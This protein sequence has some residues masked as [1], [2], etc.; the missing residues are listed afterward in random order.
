[1][2]KQIAHNNPN[3]STNKE[4]KAFVIGLSQKTTKPI[5]FDYFSSRF[6]SL[7]KVE[8]LK[9]NKKTGKIKGYGFLILN[10]KIEFERLISLKN[11][12][13][14]DRVLFVKP[15]YR[16]EELKKFKESIEKKRIYIQEIP[17]D[18]D[19]DDLLK[20]LGVFGKVEDAFIARDVKNNN[21]SKGFG[22]AT[23]DHV[24]YAVKAVNTGKVIYNGKEMVLLEFQSREKRRQE[25]QKSALVVGDSSSLE[26]ETGIIYEKKIKEKKNV[27]SDMG[28]NLKGDTSQMNNFIKKSSGNQ[29]HIRAGN[30]FKKDQTAR[31]GDKNPKGKLPTRPPPNPTGK[32]KPKNPSKSK[33]N[34]TKDHRKK[35]DGKKRQKKIEQIQ[36][37]MGNYHPAHQRDNISALVSGGQ[38]GISSRGQE[39]RRAEHIYQG[40][41]AQAGP[42][43]HYH[44]EFP[45]DPQAQPRFLNPINPPIDPISGQ[46]P[47]L[48]EDFRNPSLYNTGLRNWPADQGHRFKKRG[49]RSDR[50]KKK[51]LRNRD[52]VIES[53]EFNHS[54]D[55]LRLNKKED[56][57][58]GSN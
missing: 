46:P 2:E 38:Q 42:P 55:N 15:Y 10:S 29:K 52:V 48:N 27:S 21:E 9:K 44:S 57:P 3:N 45:D 54:D 50:R 17:S 24:D 34:I 1:M 11:F 12:Q 26:G 33:K 47:H 20:A 49:L 28:R 37:R 8:M 51:M 32:K 5:I 31:A 18:L 56:S 14:L 58:T 39:G 30:K 53:M 41:Y 25:R 23:F 19:D 35:I 4:F 7:K 6:P 40:G 43:H 22:Y 16:G 36:Q 13:V